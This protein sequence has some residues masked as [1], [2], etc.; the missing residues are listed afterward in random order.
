M[1]GGP[2]VVMHS[3]RSKI[4]MIIRNLIHNALKYTDQGKVTVELDA[5]A[6]PGHL[7]ITVRDTGIGIAAADMPVLFEMF[8]QSSSDVPRD[9]GVGLGLYIVKRLTDVLGGRVSVDSTR[10]GGSTFVVVLPLTVPATSD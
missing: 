4:E 6:T 5:E 3:D 9:G 7:C 2:D 1:P 8:S 10:G